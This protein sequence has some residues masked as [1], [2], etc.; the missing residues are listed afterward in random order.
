MVEHAVIPT[1]PK[2]AIEIDR[3]SF[4]YP[5]EEKES[6][7]VSIPLLPKYVLGLVQL[8]GDICVCIDTKEFLAAQ[9]HR[10]VN[11]EYGM[12]TVLVKVSEEKGRNY[13]AL[14][15][16]LPEVIDF[17]GKEIMWE[18]LILKTKPL[19]YRPAN[20]EGL[21]PTLVMTK[22]SLIPFLLSELGGHMYKKLD[23]IMPMWIREQEDLARNPPFRNIPF[24]LPSFYGDQQGKRKK[25]VTV[26]RIGHHLF[27]VDEDLVLGIEPVPKTITPIPQAPSWILGLWKS[28][29]EPTVVIDLGH[30]FDLDYSK[31]VKDQM[32]LVIKDNNTTFALLCDEVTGSFIEEELERK[33]KHSEDQF[34]F[35]PVSA[36]YTSTMFTEPVLGLNTKFLQSSTMLSEEQMQLSSMEWIKLL[37]NLRNIQSKVKYV[38]RFEEIFETDA[39][40][41]PREKVDVVFQQGY[42]SELFPAFQIERIEKDGFLFAGYKNF[43]VPSLHLEELLGGKKNPEDEIYGISVFITDGIEFMEIITTNVELGKLGKFNDSR[44]AI[45]GLL[46]KYENNV[47][48]SARILGQRHQLEIDLQRIMAEGYR[49]AAEKLGLKEAGLEE[50]QEAITRPAPDTSID[51]AE[52]GFFEIWR[53]DGLPFLVI[54]GKENTRAIELRK[55]EK[56]VRSPDEVEGDKEVIPW[57]EGHPS[58]PMYVIIKEEDIPKAFEMPLSAKLVILSS[59]EVIKDEKDTYIVLEG[60]NIPVLEM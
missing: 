8:E 53:K 16:P 15:I 60:S 18:H 2:I 52:E 13:F 21:G 20:I 35:A 56:I 46:N 17:D 23:E 47:I 50:I 6:Q 41:V 9:D 7:I 30:L 55:I 24:N 1:N 39:F 27:S 28:Q 3:N 25:K 38:E 26:L 19:P 10:K 33:V 12:E 54:S 36:I 32:I 58:I 31:Q 42:V 4:F 11:V 34:N 40:I 59:E 22:E 57:E 29:Y 44:V 37:S 43:W 49:Q 48:A 51:L 14:K 45:E 5:Y